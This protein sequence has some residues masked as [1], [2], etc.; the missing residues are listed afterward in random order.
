MTPALIRTLEW[1][2]DKVRCTTCGLP[3]AEHPKSLEEGY[4]C[5]VVPNVH[6]VWWAKEEIRP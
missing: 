5:I 6:A 1:D 3:W 2:T 4:F